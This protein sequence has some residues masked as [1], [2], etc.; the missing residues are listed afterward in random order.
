V[1]FVSF[2]GKGIIVI[3][4]YCSVVGIRILI[5]FHTSLYTVMMGAASRPYIRFSWQFSLAQQFYWMM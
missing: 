4:R 5:D 1:N 2:K 3:D